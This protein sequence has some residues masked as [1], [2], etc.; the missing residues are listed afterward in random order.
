M[1]FLIGANWKPTVLGG[2]TMLCLFI[3]TNPDLI[4]AVLDPV[5]S[6][7]IFGIASLVSGF[8]TFSNIKSRNVTGGTVQQTT[9]GAV[10]MPGTQSLVDATVI[11]TLQSGEPL[12][13]KHEEILHE[14]QPPQ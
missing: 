3:T 7:R 6:K 10:A 14:I 12:K 11:A 1:K 9:N 4:S 8:I 13:P 2:L 5:L